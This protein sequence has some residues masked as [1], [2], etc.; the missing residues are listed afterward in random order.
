MPAD[1]TAAARDLLTALYRAAV[2]GSNI[3]A[4]TANAVA[5]IPVERRRRVWLFAFGKAAAA[6]TTAA[7]TTLQRELNEIVGGIVV[8]SGSAEPTIGPIKV[9]LGDHP[10]PGRRSFDAAVAIGQVVM[11]KRGADLGIVL[12]S[13]GTSSLIAGP[14]ASMHEADLT[15]LYELLLRSGLDIHEMNTVRKRFGRWAAGRLALALAPAR[16]YCFAVSDV[17]GDDIASI[18]SGPCV[19]DP[20]TVNQAIDILKRAELFSRMPASFRQ[21]LADSARGVVPDTPKA[22]HPAFAHVTPHVI[23]NNAGALRAAAA[24]A[25]RAGALSI[26]HERVLVGDAATAGAQI[27]ESLLEVRATAKLGSTTC[28]MWGGETTVRVPDTEIAGGRCQELA[29]AAAQRLGRAGD[30]ASGIT[31]LAAG[32]DGRDGNTDAAGAFADS[33][34]WSTIAAAGRD[35]LA[36]LQDHR[37]HDALAA[38]HALFA[39]G[40]TGTNVMDVVL[41]VVR[42]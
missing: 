20:T 9:L 2:D 12:L 8:G 22:S 5:A 1:G 35:A 26:V 15:R 10:V 16:T 36:D 33:S 38:A 7:V 31:L 14:L 41:G 39:P 23:A 27:A 13:G 3:E 37:A 21:H 25:R 19:P 34:T 11:Q 28:V 18:G 42:V 40:A 17:P 30:A 32:T 6:M 29:L 4:L 24:A